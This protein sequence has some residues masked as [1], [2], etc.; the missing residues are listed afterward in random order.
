EGVAIIARHLRGKAK[1]AS[2]LNQNMRFDPRTALLSAAIGKIAGDNLINEPSKRI[3]KPSCVFGVLHGE[4]ER[5]AT[6]APMRRNGLGEARRSGGIMR[7][8]D[9]QGSGIA[10][11]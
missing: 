7:S 9:N 8:I 4:D 6:L 3:E 1:V 2:H 5:L 11:R 10:A